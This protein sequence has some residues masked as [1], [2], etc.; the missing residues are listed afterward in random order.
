MRDKIRSSKAYECPP[1]GAMKNSL[2]SPG[3][4]GKQ[5]DE[6]MLYPGKARVWALR[7]GEISG[8]AHLNL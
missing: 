1:T 7:L 5:V 6:I 2:T 3:L 4:S 8:K